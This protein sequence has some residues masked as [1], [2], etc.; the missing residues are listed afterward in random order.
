MPE[1]ASVSFRSVGLDVPELLRHLR[2]SISNQLAQLGIEHQRAEPSRKDSTIIRAWYGPTK[3]EISAQPDQGLPDRWTI[4]C[5]ALLPWRRRLLIKRDDVKELEYLALPPY[6]IA[7]DDALHDGDR[8]GPRTWEG[9][10]RVL[11]QGAGPNERERGE[12]F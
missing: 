5:R 10:Q 2:G 7:I 12:A 9:W 4:Q 8:F 1:S 11:Q 3:V 6:C